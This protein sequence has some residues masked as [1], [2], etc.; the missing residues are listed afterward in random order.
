MILE[1]GAPI[2]PLLLGL[3]D[4]IRGKAEGLAMARA[5]PI[6]VSRHFRSEWRRVAE[7]AGRTN[8]EKTGD[9][10]SNKEIARALDITPEMVKSHVENIFATLS[11]E[12]RAQA[13]A[14]AQSLRLVRTY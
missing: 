13:V 5:L 11:V 3:M 8:L 14:R 7:C 6:S 12:R 2:G 4:H 9:G 10:K 1:Q